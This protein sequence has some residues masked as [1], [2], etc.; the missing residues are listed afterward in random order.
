MANLHQGVAFSP[1]TTL[2]E[3]IGAADT[4][5]K[6]SD[7]SVFPDP[8]NY[9]TIGTDELGETIEYA[10]KAEGLLSGCTRG[11]EGTAKAWQKGDVIARN[12]TAK[13]HNDTITAVTTAQQ[14]ANTATE[15]AEAAQNSADNAQSTA[16][17]AK[18]TAEAALP[19]SGGVMTGPITGITTPTVDTGAANK[20]YVDSSIIRP[21]L[22]DNWYFVD[23]I[24]QRRKTSYTDP[25]YT[26]DRW[27]KFS[28]SPNVNVTSNG[29]SFAKG[30][31]GQKILT[32]DLPIGTYT[33]SALTASNK[34]AT[35]TFS[36]AAN[37]PQ[38]SFSAY[39]DEIE[40]L[41]L[42][43]FYKWRLE[44]GAS[45]F[46]F[47]NTSDSFSEEIVAAKLELGAVQTLAHKEGDTWVLNEIPD[48]A[49]ELFKCYRYYY[50]SPSAQ[51]RGISAYAV[52]TT[53]LFCFDKFPFPMRSTPT[54]SNII[55]RNAENGETVESL[56]VVSSSPEGIAKLS[57]S[58]SLTQGK[59]YQLSYE[60][61][62]DL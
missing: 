25:G 9:A 34:L 12:F 27:S 31:F 48:Y 15:A 30:D 35:T 45:L 59:Y 62:A 7:S 10:A 17:T 22:L 28:N 4:I 14:T 24:N 46:F 60:A 38:K 36:I 39:F 21:N 8:P 2:S 18:S 61:S 51:A 42:I 44:E 50:K 33:I 49:T 23:P 32:S 55:A 58:T 57:K 6:V 26:I 56:T 20:L 16:N 54:L 43:F 11:V 13:D 52:D 47:P 29:L 5:I 41:K 19:K 37:T 1:Q 3:N 53:T 40:S